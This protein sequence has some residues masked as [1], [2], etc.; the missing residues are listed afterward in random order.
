MTTDQIPISRFSMITRITEKALR[1][2]DQKG[3]LVP[4]S[5]D[6]FTGYRYYRST[7]LERG[8][9]IKTLATIGL[10][11][12]E[13]FAFLEA[14]AR[15]DS[16]AIEALLR[17]HLSNVQ[18]EIVRLHRIEALLKQNEPEELMKMALIDPSTKEVPPIRVMSRREK[19][20]YGETVGR[21]VGELTAIVYQPRNQKNQV[22]VSGP[23]ISI[24]HDQEYR[25][26]DADIEVALPITG[27]IEVDDP[28]VEVK[29]LPSVRVLSAVHKG[30]Y[31][32][33][34]ITY[35]SIFEHL[36]K[37]NMELEGPIRELYLT[38]PNRTPVEDL[39]TEIQVPI[40]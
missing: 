17:Q 5:K 26:Q 37:N 27:R 34:H 35:K 3:L 13:M 6:P 15:G 40:R 14:E 32:T 29:T 12:E 33:L 8:V 28:R 22:R 1:Y 39:L 18:E 24:Y 16:H 23:L 38:D 20:S 11:I 30:S 10:C 2:Y 36:V 21:L 4:E 19:G 9:R 25:E 7:Q 31:D